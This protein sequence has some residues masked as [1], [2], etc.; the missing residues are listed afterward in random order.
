[1]SEFSSII[2]NDLE[3]QPEKE[4]SLFTAMND[5]NNYMQ[6]LYNHYTD[7]LDEAVPTNITP[8]VVPQTRSPGVTIF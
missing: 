8:T 3:I 5:A 2:Y 6:A 4:P 1:M 7:L